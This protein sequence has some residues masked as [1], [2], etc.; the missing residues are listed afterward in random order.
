MYIIYMSALRE[1][2]LS[3]LKGEID[4]LLKAM[5]VPRCSYAGVVVG[6]IVVVVVVVVASPF[7][8]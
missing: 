1:S 5:L 6:N 3:T 2:G 8:P 4:S 7:P